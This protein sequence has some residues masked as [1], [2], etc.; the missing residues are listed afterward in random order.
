MDRISQRISMRRG[1]KFP[2]KRSDSRHTDRQNLLKRMKYTDHFKNITKRR[3]ILSV[4]AGITLGI[5]LEFV[6]LLFGIKEHMP[7]IL[8]GIIAVLLL[9][10]LD[11]LDF[12]FSVYNK[13]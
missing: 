3:L 7:F 13:R 9:A 4:I 2:R 5:V 8:L 10:L 1:R 6:L 11:W 12:Q